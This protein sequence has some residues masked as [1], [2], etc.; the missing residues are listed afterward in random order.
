MS[1]SLLKFNESGFWIHNSVAELWFSVFCEQAACFKD[2]KWVSDFLNEI[3]LALDAG[4]IDGIAMAIFD[5]YLFSQARHHIFLNIVNDTN[6]FLIN[7]ASIDDVISHGRF[8][9]SKS[10][11]IPELNMIHNLFFASNEVPDLPHVFV[12]DQG[13]VIA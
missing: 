10:F 2:K 7:Q 3:N 8:S 5:K 6:N 12:L 11:L 1:T 4:W 13:W 9:A